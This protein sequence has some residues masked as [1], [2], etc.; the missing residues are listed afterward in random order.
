M[1]LGGGRGGGR[2]ERADG[3]IDIGRAAR[4]PLDGE[5]ASGRGGRGRTRSP[6]CGSRRS[7]RKLVADTEGRQQVLTLFTRLCRNG[8]RVAFRRGSYGRCSGTGPR[9][10]G[11]VWSGPRG[12]CSSR[13]PGS[14]VGKRRARLHRRETDLGVTIQGVPFPTSV[15]RVG[16]ELQ[17]VDVCGPGVQRDVRGAGGRPAGARCGRWGRRRRSGLRHDNLIGGDARAEAERRAAT[18][19]CGFWQQVLDH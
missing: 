11:A 3:V 5:G 4:L 2:D 8:I 16:A 17:Q 15:V 12:V 7:S 9:L 1:T 19:R 18:D 13:W 6:A 10:A 14:R